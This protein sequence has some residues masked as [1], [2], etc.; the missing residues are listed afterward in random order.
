MV[1]MASRCRGPDDARMTTEPPETATASEMPGAA[2]APARF[3]RRRTSDRVVGG[4]AGGLGD[5]LNIDPILIRVAFAALMI[6][7]GAGLVLYALGWVL[8]P[9]TGRTESIAQSALRL[10]V[11]GS[12]RLGTLVLVVV[13]VIILSP[14]LTDQFV[15]YVP[16]QLLLAFAIAVVGVVLLIPR[17]QQASAGAPAMATDW[18]QRATTEPA[19]PTAASAAAPALRIRERSS[20]GWY[21]LAGA[22][23][24]VG[25]LAVV[26]AAAPV[27][28]LPAQY[29]GAGLLALG[30]GLLVGAFWGRARSLI[31]LGLALIP[32]AATAVFLTVPLEGGVADTQFR[33]QT[34]AEVRSTYRLVAGELRLDL[35]GIRASSE[36]LVITASVG[37]G[38][39]FILVPTDATVEVT[40][41]VQ[42]GRL[43]LF[44]QR[45]VGTGLSDY[46]AAQ[47]Q[48]GGTVMKLKLEV[49][50]GQVQV[51]RSIAEGY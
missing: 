3:L 47:G 33:P 37:V 29:V 48:A 23:L 7:G 2:P 25:A 21:V 50:M 8:I 19:V 20:L 5:Y 34:A 27:R 28:V 49:G 11:S 16:P 41:A 12:G 42:G 36:P 31:L 1:P 32:L 10:V 38:A 13:V 24:A 35:T 26:N 18:V 39:I 40:G 46:I 14:W 44:G 6:F 22:S 30:I 45:H 43:L 4:V 15:T 51:G 17:G 9:E